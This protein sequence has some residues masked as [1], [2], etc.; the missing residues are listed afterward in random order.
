MLATKPSS[1]ILGPNLSE[2]DLDPDFIRGNLL[3]SSLIS[4]HLFR[5]LS[6]PKFL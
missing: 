6:S 1:E 3:I 5:Q 4:M 2:D